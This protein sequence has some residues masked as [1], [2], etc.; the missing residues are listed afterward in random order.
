[1]KPILPGKASGFAKVA[2]NP[3]CGS[4]TPTQFGPMI[5]IRP[6]RARISLSNSTPAGP[7]SLNPAETMTAPLTPA[8]A[9]SLT[10]PGT[11]AAGVAMTA[12]SIGA[13]IAPIPE[14]AFCPRTVGRFGFT[15]YTRRL[16]A[17]RF[18]I[19]ARPTLPG[20]SPAPITAT[21]SGANIASKIGRSS[22]SMTAGGFLPFVVTT[23]LM[24]ACFIS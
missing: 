1:M 4:I 5:R 20:V 24:R 12:R 15:G 6:W 2:F 9:H 16:K 13:L 21:D 10:M 8:A 14:Y 23:F 3:R 19:R 18:S 7:H 11:V 22:T 17:W